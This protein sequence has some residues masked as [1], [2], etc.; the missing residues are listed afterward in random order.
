MKNLMISLTLVMLSTLQGFA[1]ADVEVAAAISGKTIT[2]SFE[3]NS[4]KT[5]FAFNRQRVI[6]KDLA[7]VILYEETI[8]TIATP[9]KNYN[10]KALP[11][12]EYLFEIHDKSKVTI[13]PFTIEGEEITLLEESEIFQPTVTLKDK[14]AIFNLLAFQNSVEVKVWDADGLEL[15]SQNFEDM[16]SVGKR[17]DFSTVPTG[18]YR[19]T[20]KV[21]DQYF[22]D[23]I[24]IE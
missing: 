5:S 4:K 21:K 9:E 8:S 15:F 10:L 19:I 1:F 17:F 7:G 2:L 13:K 18:T 22:V 11:N 16:N 6:L 20:T 12:G 14:V 24:E 23:N 3:E